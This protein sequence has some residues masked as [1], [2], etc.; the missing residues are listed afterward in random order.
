MIKIKS[1][2][3]NNAPLK[4]VSFFVGYS[5][6]FIFGHAQTITTNITV[7]LCFYGAEDNLNIQ[8]PETVHLELTGKRS[9]MQTVDLKNL[10]IHI[11]ARELVAGTQPIEIS[12][13]S[14]FLP[15]SIKLVHYT[16]AQIVVTVEHNKKNPEQ[17]LL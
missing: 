12:Q 11:D 7:P 10:A 14:L 4:I 3:T 9:I 6:W 16:P 15:E 1:L 13:K 8:A 17:T 2:I 5:F